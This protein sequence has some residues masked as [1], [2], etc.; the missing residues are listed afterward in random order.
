MTET[1]KRLPL[2]MLL[3]ATFG[4]LAGACG[5]TSEYRIENSCEDYCARA[6]DC[7]DNTDYS[8][9]VDNCLDTADECDSESDLENALDRLDECTEESCDDVAAC[10][11]DAL[12][13]C[14]I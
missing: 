6:V 3:A 8:D 9:C 5:P 2:A 11:V 10:S 4:L 12:I 13:E 1:F 14:A 7:N